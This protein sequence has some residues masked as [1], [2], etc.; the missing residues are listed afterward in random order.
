MSGFDINRAETLATEN[1]G[2]DTGQLRQLDDALAA[3]DATGIK[4]APSYG[5]VSPY[6]WRR[7]EASH[8]DELKTQN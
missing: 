3:L 6:E 2:V 7:L 1:P 5:L 8:S 4:G